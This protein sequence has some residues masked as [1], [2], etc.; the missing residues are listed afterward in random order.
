MYAGVSAAA[1]FAP[2]V[3]ALC[4]CMCES[5][6]GQT[7]R[8][9]QNG[10]TQE[11]MKNVTGGPTHSTCPPRAP[12]ILTGYCERERRGARPADTACGLLLT[13]S[14]VQA[15]EAELLAILS[16]LLQR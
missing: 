8:P 13:P 14:S 1:L 12:L 10:A 9:F 5:A 7:K 3:G 11:L 2:C 4:I 6:D 16:A 15:P